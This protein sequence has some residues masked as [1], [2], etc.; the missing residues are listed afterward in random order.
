M[1]FC[2]SPVNL[3]YIN[4]MINTVKKLEGKKGKFSI[5]SGAMS[6]NGVSSRE[7]SSAQQEETFLSR[8]NDAKNVTS[9][10]QCRIKSQRQSLE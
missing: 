5:L 4:L 6:A 3:P 1:K 2:F 9:V 7:R 8:A 10:Y